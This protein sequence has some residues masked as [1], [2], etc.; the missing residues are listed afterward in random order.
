MATAGRILIMPKGAF[1][2]STVYEQLDLVSHNG[3]A[4]LAKKS[5]VGIE[6][7]EDNTEYWHDFL[8]IDMITY[9]E[10]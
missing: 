5:S 9:E 6:P 2:P 3:K 1:N 10:L 7:R 8:G 4:W